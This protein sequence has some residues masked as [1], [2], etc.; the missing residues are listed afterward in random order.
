MCVGDRSLWF[1]PC[2]VDVLFSVF[3]QC[4]ACDVRRHFSDSSLS[5]LLLLHRRRFGASLWRVG[6]EGSF[7]SPFL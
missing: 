2:G 4:C 6:A 3:G 1:P 7:S 5:L